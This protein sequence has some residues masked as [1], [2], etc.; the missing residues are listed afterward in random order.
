LCGLQLYRL[1]DRRILGPKPYVDN[2]ISMQKREEM[3]CRGREK[4]QWGCG[5]SI[6]AIDVTE[7]HILSRRTIVGRLHTEFGTRD[8]GSELLEANQ[9]LMNVSEMSGERGGDHGLR[10]YR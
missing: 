2:K 7:T 5:S 1:D 3:R 6:A 9:W 8:S 4:R 10:G